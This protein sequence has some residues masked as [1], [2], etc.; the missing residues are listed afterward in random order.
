MINVNGAGAG[1]LVT[2]KPSVKTYYYICVFV[3]C[4]LAIICAVICLHVVSEFMP[5]VRS[6][7]IFAALILVGS[8][9][10][11]LLRML[12]VK[13]ELPAMLALAAA[14]YVL[15]FIFIKVELTGD[16]KGYYDRAWYFAYD[17]LY[18]LNYAAAFPHIMR[19]PKFLSY[20]IRLFGDGAEVYFGINLCAVLGAA[21][22]VY[23]FRAQLGRP[24]ARLAAFIFV[25]NPLIIVYCLVPNA[26]LLYGFCALAALYLHVSLSNGNFA[27]RCAKYLAVGCC[28]AAAN[29][30]R[31][32]GVIAL[33]AIAID[34][35]FRE[36]V[37][38]AGYALI[39]AVPFTAGIVLMNA[40]TETI[41]GY[42]PVVSPY[43]WNLYVGASENGTWNE[44]DGERFSRISD[45]LNDDPGEIQAFFRDAGVER[46]KA[47]GLSVFRLFYKKLNLFDVKNHINSFLK[48]AL[49]RFGPD[50]P[51]V[52]ALNGGIISLCFFVFYL[53]AF[54]GAA[55]GLISRKCGDRLAFLAAVYLL[56]SF[57][58][59]LIL[60]AA[61]RHIIS[62]MPLFS[63]L[64]A[65]AA[66]FPEKLKLRF[67]KK[68]PER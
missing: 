35:L 23:R 34:L 59:F 13:W 50:S 57:L 61:H 48:D 53:M 21:A 49:R 16:I 18:G 25:F 10:A 28:C 40:Q 32:L 2:E 42:K 64:A 1:K 43:G 15:A 27:W 19:Y 66:E 20:F 65:N 38:K 9:P 67:R 46:Y 37:K 33:I 8:V 31:P 51:V 68:I 45:E 63:V 60:E 17:R 41:T 4:C 47:M 56:G 6:V 55:Y 62:Y 52:L 39:I 7:A 30:F 12:S 54:F 5:T 36:G 3:A 22:I 44:A 11:R 24:A 14:L 58:V 29:Y 26:E